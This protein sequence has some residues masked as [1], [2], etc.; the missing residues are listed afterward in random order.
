LQRCDGTSGKLDFD[1]F[2]YPEL[3]SVV[4]ESHYRTVN[5]SRSD[6]LI[7]CLQVIDHLL[8]FLPLALRR[9]E[10]DQIENTDDENEQK[11]GRKCRLR[12]WLL[13]KHLKSPQ[14]P[15]LCEE[16]VEAMK[17][18]KLP[19]SADRVKV[20]VQVMNGVKHRRENLIRNEQ[21]PQIRTRIRLTNDASTGRI[22]RFPVLVNNHPLRA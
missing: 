4:F 21:M 1:I 17:L 15:C 19:D 11:W 2:S 22:D 13:E 6:D 7:A 20:E 18:D 12:L 3:N 10:D 14:S 16:F 5:P 8:E 9:E